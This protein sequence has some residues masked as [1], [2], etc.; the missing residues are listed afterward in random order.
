[1]ITYGLLY[2]GKLEYYHRKVLP[3]I[4]V[5]W[6]Q[7]TDHPYRKGSC[8]VFRLPFT[9]PGFYIGK[10]IVG[11]DLEFEDDKEIDNRLSDAMKVRKI[12][13]PEDGSYEDAFFKE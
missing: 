10:W 1:M 6:T 13:E 2:G 12:W 4:E 9:K 7:E 11:S 3:I 5:G 8:L